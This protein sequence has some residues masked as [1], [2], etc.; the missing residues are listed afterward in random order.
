M[1][2]TRSSTWID[3]AVPVIGISRPGQSPGAVQK[4]ETRKP[5]EIDA[6]QNPKGSNWSS[7]RQEMQVRLDFTGVVL[8]GVGE[9]HFCSR[10]GLL[11]I[12]ADLR[13]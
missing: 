11:P 12:G 10:P 8:E 5:H 4:G 9:N 7:N 6:H 13:S 2:S 1:L 3:S